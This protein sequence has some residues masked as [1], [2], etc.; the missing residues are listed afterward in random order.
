MCLTAI[1]KAAIVNLHVFLWL[2]KSDGFECR[3]LP[4]HYSS[5]HVFHC[6]QELY[7]LFRAAKGR[8][9]ARQEAIFCTITVAL[10]GQWGSHI[11]R[12]LQQQTVQVKR[13]EIEVQVMHTYKI[14]YATQ[15]MPVCGCT[16]H[17]SPIY[18]VLT[19]FH[20]NRITNLTTRTCI[21]ATL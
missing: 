8:L 11:Q 16:N 9:L 15:P 18:L 13:Q 7:K 4:I 6:T 5:T 10:H 19:D 1:C 14:L 20:E 17:M 2:D 21:Y 12:R 3:A